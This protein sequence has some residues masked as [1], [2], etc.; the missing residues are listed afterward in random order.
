M[1]EALWDYYLTQSE[2]AQMAGEPLPR[3]VDKMMKEGSLHFLY[4][5]LQRS[6]RQADCADKLFIYSKVQQYDYFMV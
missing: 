5:G 2:D 4:P 3:T 1:L 6:Q